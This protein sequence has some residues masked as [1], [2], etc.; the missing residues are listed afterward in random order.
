MERS[1][2]VIKGLK[3]KALDA[4]RKYI[5]QQHIIFNNYVT[6]IMT[7]VMNVHNNYYW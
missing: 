5:K 7:S 1:S 2:T 6:I 3:I 4:H